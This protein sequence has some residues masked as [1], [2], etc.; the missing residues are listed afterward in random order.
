MT[1]A[2]LRLDVC[3]YVGA[4]G[5]GTQRPLEALSLFWISLT[6]HGR[7]ISTFGCLGLYQVVSHKHSDIQDMLNGLRKLCTYFFKGH[8]FEKEWRRQVELEN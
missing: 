5:L 6:S 3:I 7:S 8:Q 1:L 4:L 2:S